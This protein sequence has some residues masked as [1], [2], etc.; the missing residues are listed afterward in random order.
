MVAAAVGVEE[1]VVVVDA[2]GVKHL[3]C[4][5]NNQPKPANW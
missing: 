1:E 3:T 2:A 5:E 4:L